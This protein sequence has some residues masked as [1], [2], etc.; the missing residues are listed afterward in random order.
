MFYHTY[1]INSSYLGKINIYKTVYSKLVSRQKKKKGLLLPFVRL[2][3]L[4]HTLLK[5]TVWLVYVIMTPVSEVQRKFLV[6]YLGRKQG[7]KE[8]WK[9]GAYGRH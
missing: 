1:F 3:C 5:W 9:K 8:M 2:Q 6:A 4:T 7:G